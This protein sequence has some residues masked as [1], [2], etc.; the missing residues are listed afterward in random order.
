[1]DECVEL[2]VCDRVDRG[3]DAFVSGDLAWPTEPQAKSS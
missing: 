1:V 2:A 3:R